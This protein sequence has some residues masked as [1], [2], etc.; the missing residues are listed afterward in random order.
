MLEG[1][2]RGHLDQL[3]PEAEPH[4]CD[5]C[6]SPRRR[7]YSPSAP[8][9]S[10]PPPPQHRSAFW[11]SCVP[12]CIHC[13]LCCHWAPPQPSYCSLPS[14]KIYAQVPFSGVN[15]QSHL[16]QIFLVWEIFHYLKTYN[17]QVH[18]KVHFH[19]RQVN[20]AVMKKRKGTKKEI[21]SWKKRN[22]IL[23]LL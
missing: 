15:K 6:R 12:F 9:A 10:S 7:L 3:P 4:A 1:T 5:F 19:N 23:E 2:S 16:S 17:M 21:S 11:C 14:D 22:K 20:K 8:C 13:L 18:I